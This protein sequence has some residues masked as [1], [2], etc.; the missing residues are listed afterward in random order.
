MN[1]LPFF[2]KKE[3]NRLFILRALIVFMAWLTIAAALLLS[4]F[5][6]EYVWLY[7][8]SKWQK[9]NVKVEK[10]L[11]QTKN[12]QKDNVSNEALS[13]LAGQVSSHL[14]LKQGKL[15]RD[16]LAVLSKSNV[17]LKTLSLRVGKEKVS[18]IRVELSAEANNKEDIINFVQ[19]LQAS[20]Y[21]NIDMS[22]VVSSLRVSPDHRIGFDIPLLINIP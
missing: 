6:A 12:S 17:V 4:V 5:F 20:G 22:Q 13:L 15:L 2:K 9:Q 14:S 1:V 11:L 19:A 21:K 3:L 10:S 18:Q 16:I 7:T 8:E